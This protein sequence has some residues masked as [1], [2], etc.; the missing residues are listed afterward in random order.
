MPIIQITMNRQNPN[1]PTAPAVR[2]HTYLAVKLV[3]LMSLAL[4]DTFNLRLMD[5]LH[6]VL[7]ASLLDENPLCY[8]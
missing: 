5:T 3:S 8:L 2:C 7:I 4:A 1:K 6:L